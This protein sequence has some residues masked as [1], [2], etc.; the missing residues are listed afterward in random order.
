MDPYTTRTSP[1]SVHI[2]P[3]PGHTSSYHLE[4]QFSHLY[5][6]T[7]EAPRA[8]KLDKG[9]VLRQGYSTFLSTHSF[10]QCLLS[11]YCVPCTILGAKNKPEWLT[12][13]GLLLSPCPRP[14]PIPLIPYT[15]P[16][17]S[18]G[19]WAGAAPGTSRL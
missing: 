12:L 3:H 11:S 5:D 8:Q 10:S 16:K 13:A 18:L 19:A 1:T 15:S 17:Y 14:R 4:P 9:V 7:V 2:S 6:G